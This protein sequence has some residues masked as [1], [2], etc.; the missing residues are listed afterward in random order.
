MTQS[1]VMGKVK[2]NIKIKLKD[3]S[4]EEGGASNQPEAE[5]EAVAE[6]AVDTVAASGNKDD[7][8]GKI[9]TVFVTFCL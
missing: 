6:A 3:P 8:V 7:Q 9:G 1:R 5:G 4:E 2:A